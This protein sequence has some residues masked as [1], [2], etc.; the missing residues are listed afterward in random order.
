M[1]NSKKIV[2]NYLKDKFTS[3]IQKVR[4]KFLT[5]INDL[6]T[7]IFGKVRLA[8]TTH[9]LFTKNKKKK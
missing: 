5:Y 3:T 4:H 7:V 9:F 6:R 2:V 8:D 1:K